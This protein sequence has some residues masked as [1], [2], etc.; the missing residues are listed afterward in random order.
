M[1]GAQSYD[2]GLVQLD[3]TAITLRRYHFPSGTSKIVAL[4]VIRGYK[5]EPLGLLSQRFQLWGSSDLRRWLPLDMHRPVRSTLV[6]LDLPR[7]RLR[8]AFTPAQPEEFL[9][10][11]DELLSQRV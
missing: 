2:D 9:A 4:N 3:R 1:T 6:T 11:L 8:P 7:H 10:L 5:A